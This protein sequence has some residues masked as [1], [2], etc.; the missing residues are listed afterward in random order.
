MCHSKTLTLGPVTLAINTTSGKDMA[1]GLISCKGKT[2][3]FM[4]REDS[5]DELVQMLQEARNTMSQAV[6]S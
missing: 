3:R 5:L 4:I 2:Q 1:E 6:K